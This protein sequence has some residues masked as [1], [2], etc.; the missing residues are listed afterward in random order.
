MAPDT[1]KNNPLSRRVNYTGDDRPADRV[2][3]VGPAQIS[4]DLLLCNLPG[5]VYRCLNDSSWTMQFV[6]EGVR[7]LTGYAPAV[8]TSGGEF[9]F[10]NVIHPLDRGE[11][12]RQVD[13]AVATCRPYQMTYRILTASGEIKWVWE[14][15]AGIRN[16]LGQ[17]IALEGFIADFTRVKMADELVVEQASFLDQARDAIFVID[18]RRRVTY[19]NGGAERLF[20]WSAAEAVG[21]SIGDLIDL[22]ADAL[23]HACGSALSEGEWCGEI[24]H[25]HKDG[26]AVDTQAHWSLIP[27]NPVTGN[28]QKILAISAD[29]RDRKKHE[30]KIFRLAFFDA[31]TELPNRT[32]LLN[33]L[34]KALLNSVRN[35]K[36]GALM[37][38]DLDNFK[39]LNDT[40]GHAA[41]DAMLQAVS[42][43]LQQSVRETDVVARLGGD[44]FVIL[45][46]PAYQSY[47]EAARRAESAAENVLRNLASPIL[48]A[49]KAHPV[50]TSIGVT[51]F[52]GGVDTV[53]SVLMKADTAMYQAKSAGRNTL[54]FF[55]PA[56]Q[57]AINAQ[58]QLQ[59]EMDQALSDGAFVLYYQP[60]L[61]EHDCTVGAEALIRWRR[62]DGHLTLPA[63]FIK[64][65]EVTG[66]IQELGAWVLST[67]C[68]QLAEW[69]KCG[70]TRELTLSV[71]VSAHQ[72][73]DPGF[74]STVLGLLAATGADP[75]RLR[76]EL[77][78]SL[79]FRDTGEAVATMRS[80]KASGVTFTI[81]DF[82]TGYS[83]LAYLRHFPIDQLKIDHSFMRG[84]LSDG[85]DA[86][87]VRSILTL[88][89][90]LGISVIAE[91][92]ETQA[93]RDFLA[94]A[95]C[96]R[97]QGFLYTHALPNELF[98]QFASR[99]NAMS[100]AQ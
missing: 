93:Q 47:E 4:V 70:A 26:G 96:R 31:L 8:F 65:A 28:S 67:A 14:Q 69:A 92:V 29:I 43:R 77:T 50:S 48:L 74:A 81:D 55:D 51:L 62:K 98:I 61:D 84:V 22:E 21:T 10:A 90:N 24:V 11:V 89:N 15:G 33:S 58:Q 7:D 6:S 79:L 68:L 1:N 34:H 41:G 36:I 39:V 56:I 82:G 30:A 73:V 18:M 40:K 2:Q 16:S 25:R 91:G 71:N 94:S 60:Q 86:A 97:F 23:M 80:L 46:E 17:V 99:A 5:A 19:W 9:S 38:C 64:A 52:S 76:M 32:S 66:Q 87:I 53:E 88:G 3:T 63:R 42:R 57:A 12:A 20:G 78:E 100:A 44:E 72:F 54:R 85:N 35:Q 13:L 45:L 95:G 59:S 83:S 75:R 27:A 49:G 37:F